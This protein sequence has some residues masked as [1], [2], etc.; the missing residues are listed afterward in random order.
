[1]AEGYTITAPVTVEGPANV[2][3]SLSYTSSPTIWSLGRDTSDTFYLG[4]QDFSGLWTMDLSGTISQMGNLVVNGASTTVL[5]TL[6]ISGAVG[7]HN[8]LTVT[9]STVVNGN[10]DVSGAVS[11]HG[12]SVD[13]RGTLDVSGAVGVHNSLTVTGNFDVSGVAS[14]KGTAVHVLGMLDVSGTA[15]V[16]ST[17][18]STTPSSGALVVAGGFGVNGEVYVGGSKIDLSSGGGYLNLKGGSQ[19]DFKIDEDASGGGWIDLIGLPLARGNLVRDPIPVDF[20]GQIFVNSF[21]VYS[22]VTIPYH[23]PHEYAPGT[24]MFIH[25]HYASVTPNLFTGR[26][27]RWQSEYTYSKGNQ[28]SAFFSAPIVINVQEEVPVGTLKHRILEIPTAIPASLG[29]EPDGIL[30][31][32]TRR[33]PVQGLGITE[34][35]DSLAVLSIDIHMQISKLTTKN[36]S[37]PFYA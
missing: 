2:Q 13:I 9:G 4:N 12:T 28:N 24:D 31:I 23:I 36:R 26:Y 6:D 30:T 21:K 20:I 5:G 3:V 32:R 22:E 17:A 11:L 19:P 1:M 25:V 18:A 14:L 10:F 33:L 8:A 15:T 7:I 35:P 27:V 29:L 37:F 34:Y 16:H